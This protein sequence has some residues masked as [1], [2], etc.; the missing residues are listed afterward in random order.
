MVVAEEAGEVEEEAVVQVNYY[1]IVYKYMA[2]LYTEQSKNV[3]K[4]WMLMSVFLIIVIG[5]GFVFSR[6]YSNQNIL[7]IFS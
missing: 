7:Y 3:S 2:T 1:D 6:M 5:L 4:T